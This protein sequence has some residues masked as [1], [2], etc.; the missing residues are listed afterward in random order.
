MWISIE[1]KEID[2]ELLQNIWLHLFCNRLG[3]AALVSLEAAVAF[4][5]PRGRRPGAAA[6]PA[7]LTL[8]SGLA[9]EPVVVRGSP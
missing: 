2:M 8:Q 1:L 9:Q 3:G 6:G 5:T 7:S 4:I